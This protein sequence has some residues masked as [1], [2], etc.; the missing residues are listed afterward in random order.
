MPSYRF[1]IS[2]PRIIP[3]GC[4]EGEEPVNEEGVRFYSNLIDELLHHGIEPWVTLYHWDL[5]AQLENNHGGM[6]GSRFADAFLFFAKT[7]FLRFGD[8]VKHWITLNEPWCVAVLGFATGEQAPGRTSASTSE[9]YIVGHNMLLAHAKVV[10][11]YRREIAPQHG[12]QIGITFNSDWNEP[13]ESA[14]QEAAKLIMAFRLG[15]YADPVY[16]GDYPEVMKRKLGSRLPTFTEEEKI[17]LK[18]SSDFFGLNYYSTH[19][20]GRRSEPPPDPP[21]IIWDD[22]PGFAQRDGNYPVSDMGWSIVPWGL[23][24]L[25]RYIHETYRPAGGIIITENGCAVNEPSVDAALKSSVRTDY[26]RGHLL[27]VSRAIRE[28]GVNCTG[29]FAWSLLDNFEWMFG[30]AKRFGLVYVDYESQ[31][32]TIKPAGHWY[33][34]LVSTHKSKSK[35][36]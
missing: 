15:W 17:L 14:D 16:F 18:G 13:R 24:K 28:D 27:E 26:F 3:N 33:S 11:F 34:Q 36:L 10:D 7:C 32:R 2:W 20:I 25:L 31:K 19:W 35:T 21:Q 6:R 22:D 23:R 4:V 30:Y 12:G 5:P 29:Y 9:P 1:S 8:R